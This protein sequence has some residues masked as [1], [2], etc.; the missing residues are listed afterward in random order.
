VRSS[1]RST[2]ARRGRSPPSAAC[3]RRCI[4]SPTAPRPST[5]SS[6]P[7]APRWRRRFSRRA[8]RPQP[9]SRTRSCRRIRSA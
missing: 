5:T 6:I 7:R 8:T 1:S 3:S 2:P 4:P 9:G